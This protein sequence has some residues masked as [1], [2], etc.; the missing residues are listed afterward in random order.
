[1]TNDLVA[2]ANKFIQPLVCLS[3]VLNLGL[4]WL[5][6][7]EIFRR[8]STTQEIDRKSPVQPSPSVSPVAP[9][10]PLLDIIYTAD[11]VE[12]MLEIAF[13]QR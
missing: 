11:D 7:Q 3:L 4:G 9:N 2:M 5:F 10:L 13:T 1:M 8:P 12:G 6:V